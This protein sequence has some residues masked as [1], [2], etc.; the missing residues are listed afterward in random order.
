MSKNFLLLQH[1]KLEYTKKLHAADFILSLV[2]FSFYYTNK[3]SSTLKLI[4]LNRKKGI[5]VN[6]FQRPKLFAYIFFL[7]DAPSYCIS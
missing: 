2:S 5:Y 3:N 4:K 1:P 7:Q 6:H